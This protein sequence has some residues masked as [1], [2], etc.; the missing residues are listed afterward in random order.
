MAFVF[1]KKFF[2]SSCMTEVF[3][4]PGFLALASRVML[5]EISVV[6][7]VGRRKAKHLPTTR[8]DFRDLILIQKI[9][10][11]DK[12]KVQKLELLRLLKDNINRHE[13]LIVF[14]EDRQPSDGTQ[15]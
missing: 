15:L 13:L 3:F 12:L 14:A 7:E 9:V 1:A 5:S 10:E 6:K 11:G 2:K 8:P 4:E